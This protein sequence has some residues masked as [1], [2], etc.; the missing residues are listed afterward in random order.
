MRGPFA[1]SV[2]RIAVSV[3]GGI[4]LGDWMGFGLAGVFA[5]VAAGFFAYGA[6]MA[7][8]V[9]PGVWR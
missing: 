9:R 1:A 7:A 6:I 2:S 3:G 4:V 5:S 8:S